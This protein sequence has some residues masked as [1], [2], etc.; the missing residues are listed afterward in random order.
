MKKVILELDLHEAMKL[1]SVC[2]EVIMNTEDTLDGLYNSYAK[3]MGKQSIKC[4]KAIR[5][6]IK[7]AITERN[8][9]E[10]NEGN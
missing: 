4:I 3:E 1:V 2:N 10:I 7:S 8:G 9:D 5:T 6:K